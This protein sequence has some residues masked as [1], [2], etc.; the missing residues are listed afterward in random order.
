MKKDSLQAFE[1][2]RFSNGEKKIINDLLSVEEPLGIK[3][4]WREKLYDISVTM[5]TPGQDEPLGVGFLFTEGIIQSYKEVL[6]IHNNPEDSSLVVEIDPQLN[7][8]IQK[9]QRNFYTTS[10]C[11]VCGKA[12]I[13]AVKTACP[14]VVPQKKWKVKSSFLLELPQKLRDAQ[15]SFDFSGGIHAS[16][17]FNLDSELIDIKEDVGRHNALDKLIGAQFMNHKIPLFNEVLILSGRGS[18]ELVQKAAMAG[19]R[20]IACVGAPSSL[21]VELAEEYDITLIGF[22]KTDRFNVYSGFD[23]VDFS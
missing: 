1:I 23:R 14:V 21:A 6:N 12:S 18:F 19:I 13:D 2:Q 3:I 7:W 20:F 9:L 5:R 15:K 11:G 17:L 8:E 16:A 4:Q 10:S 22:L